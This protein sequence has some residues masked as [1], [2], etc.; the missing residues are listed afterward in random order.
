MISKLRLLVIKMTI[1]DSKTRDPTPMPT[2]ISSNV[3][4]LAARAARGKVSRLSCFIGNQVDLLAVHHVTLHP[5]SR[6]VSLHGAAAEHV[7][8][9]PR[10]GRADHQH[11]GA[12]GIREGPPFGSLALVGFLRVLV[13]TSSKGQMR[14][15][16]IRW[17]SISVALR[18]SRVTRTVAKPIVK[19]A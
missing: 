4:P 12:I 10:R 19:E 18:S 15:V 6:D 17:T 3:M 1:T 11:V 8:V 16:S 5:A 7:A 9:G 14:S 13:L 2:I